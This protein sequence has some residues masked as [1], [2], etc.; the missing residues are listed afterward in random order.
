M[1]VLITGGAGYVASI[2]RPSLEAEHDC[3]YLDLKPVPDA[4]D[5]SIVGD[6]S[7]VALLTKSVR[8]MDVVVWLAMGKCPNLENGEH[9]ID[10]AFNV[11]VRD[12]YRILNV[13]HDAGVRRFVYASSLSVY[14][15]KEVV[16]A[17]PIDE[18]LPTT[19]WQPYGV[20]KRIGEFLGEALVQR[21][22]SVSFIS[23]R[24]MFPRHDRDWTGPP[25][26]SKHHSFPIGPN[27]TRRLFSAAI[28]HA[29]P[30][31][32]VVNATGDRNGEYFIQA[33][34]DQ[35]LGWRPHVD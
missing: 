35:L 33:Q 32:A 19:A 1:K 21:D 28:E 31:Y 23:L 5:R 30:G 15:V 7:N 11:N 9:D 12:L 26:G 27:D 3:W 25:D 34:A 18:R 17:H 22:P 10:A 2:I 20:S 6:L 29:E 14:N 13:A 4:D 24:L 8:G 16:D